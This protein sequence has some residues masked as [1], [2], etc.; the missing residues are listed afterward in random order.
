MDKSSAYLWFLSHKDDPEIYGREVSPH[1]TTS[2]LVLWEEKRSLL[3]VNHLIYQSWSWPGGHA[4]GDRD[5]DFCARR[6]VFEE[7]GLKLDQE[8]LLLDVRLLPVKSHSRKGA[9]V[10]AHKHLNF[11]YAY[12]IKNPPDL[13]PKLDENKGVGWIPIDELASWV[14]EDHMLDLYTDLLDQWLNL[15]KRP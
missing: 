8:G 14:S 11:T 7:T 3:M 9:L 4:D 2:A 15:P 10:A 13:H 1:I 6:E 12:K 5:L